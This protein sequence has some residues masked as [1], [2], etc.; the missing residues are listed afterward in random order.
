MIKKIFLYV[1]VFLTNISV[2]QYVNYTNDTGWNL[3]INIGG[4]WQEP[5]RKNNNSAFN[6][7]FAGFSR[8]FTVGKGVYENKDKFFSVDLRLRYL[9]GKNSG[10]TATADSFASPYGIYSTNFISDDSVYAYTNYQMKFNEFTFEGVLTLNKLREKTGLILYG[11]GGIGLTYYNINRDILN[12][13]SDST[14]TG[15]PYD[16]S[17]LTFISD[18]QTARDL[19]RLSD[20]NFETK[21][22]T[23]KLKFMPSLGFGIGYQFNE[24][25]SMGVEHKITYGLSNNINDIDNS[26]IND[27]Y[28]YTAL[29]LNFDISSKKPTLSYNNQYVP[30]S[31]TSINSNPPLNQGR[32]PLVKRVNPSDNFYTSR[33]QTINFSNSIYNI[34]DNF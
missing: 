30:E 27:K 9:K 21:I 24:R 1:I 18:R 19:K 34:E 5:E 28:H 20:N 3:G 16:Y 12:E 10:W 14:F 26:Q 31:S 4:S 15:D 29:K 6:N 13:T 11:F 17:S 22:E 33:V 32:P 23:N 8:G 7:P 2:A 25:W